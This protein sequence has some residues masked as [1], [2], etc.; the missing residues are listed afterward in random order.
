MQLANQLLRRTVVGSRQYLL[1][2]AQRRERATAQGGRHVNSWAGRNPVSP[3]AAV[4]SCTKLPAQMAALS[5]V[6]QR[7]PQLQR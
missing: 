5:F 4:P 1:T 3:L 7:P 2:G 6:D